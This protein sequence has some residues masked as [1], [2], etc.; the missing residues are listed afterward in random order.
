MARSS[1]YLIAALLVNATSKAAVS[2]VKTLVLAEALLHSQR[3]ARARLKGNNNNLLLRAALPESAAA[4]TLVTLDTNQ[5][6][7]VDPDE[8]KDFALSQGLDASAAERE[9]FSLDKNEDGSLDSTEL[10]SALALDRGSSTAPTTVVEHTAVLRRDEATS[11]R[12]PAVA[13]AAFV[14]GE[15]APIVRSAAVSEASAA[16]AVAA[17]T[18]VAKATAGPTR[19]SVMETLELGGRI[20]KSREEAA[21]AA[22]SIVDQL[23]VEE[24]N[25]AE[26]QVFERRAQDMR[27]NATLLS[28]L[29]MERALDAASRAASIKA[30]EFLQNLTL[31]EETAKRAEV[32]A[33]ALRA[34]SKAEL[35]EA[36]VLMQVADTALKLEASPTVFPSAELP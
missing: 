5:D 31:L 14:A 16:V 11:S 12:T 17:A 34:K 28:R 33:A 18:G 15:D 29:T 27:S 23:S 32:Q 26:A 9:F 19:T 1:Y 22:T 4:R 10:A 36:D 2:R 24:A 30:A 6:G 13:A 35:R 8:V 20:Y 25:E 21:A 3:H 7:H